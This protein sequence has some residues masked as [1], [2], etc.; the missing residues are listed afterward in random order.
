MPERIGTVTGNGKMS[1]IPSVPRHSSYPPSHPA[2]TIV[3]T[4][5]LA[6]EAGLDGY[7][8]VTVKEQDCLRDD[9]VTDDTVVRGHHRVQ[10][11]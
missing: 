11:S 3:K 7:P 2:I 5:D 1:L 6:F 8:T 4:D 9:R 10:S